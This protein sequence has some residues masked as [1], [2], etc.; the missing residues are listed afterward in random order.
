MATAEAKLLDLAAA[1]RK[2]LEGAGQ[3]GSRKE[4]QLEKDA[5]VRSGASNQDWAS[6][7]C[8]W[9]CTIAERPTWRL[10]YLTF[11]IPS[12]TTSVPRAQDKRQA[13]GGTGDLLIHARIAAEAALHVILD[14]TRKLEA[15]VISEYPMKRLAEEAGNHER[16]VRR[17]VGRGVRGKR[18]GRHAVWLKDG[19]E[20]SR[21]VVGCMISNH[22]FASWY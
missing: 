9:R 15:S 11:C 14:E 7:G 3:E 22:L 1:T 17:V 4:Q 8:D 21:E 2:V 18:H 13:A 20:G 10:C 19:F 16:W 12:T 6:A 5:H